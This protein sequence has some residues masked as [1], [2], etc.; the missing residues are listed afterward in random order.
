MRLLKKLQHRVGVALSPQEHY[1]RAFSQG[2][3]L[4]RDK[5]A[6]AAQLFEQ[7]ARHAGQAQDAGLQR[8]AN[9]NALLYGFLAGGSPQTLSPLLQALDGLDDIEQIGSQAEF[10]DAKALHH[11][12]AA[13]LAEATIAVLDPSA[14]LERARHHRGAARYFEAIGGQALITYAHR[15]DSLGI[16]RA[17]LRS[18]FH[19]GQARYHEALDQAHTDPEAAADAMNEALVALLQAPAKDQQQAAE[20]WLERLRTQRSCWS[21]G[22]EFLG[23]ELHYHHVPATVRGYV[24]EVLRR[25]G[26]DLASVDLSSQRVVLCATCGTMVQTIADAQAVRRVTEL[27]AEVEAQFA[28]LQHQ[29]AGLERRV[30][31]LSVR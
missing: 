15:P 10:V 30:N 19:D 12:L 2:V 20:R 9:A 22:R 14:H 13:R 26:H 31:A 23:A 8:R 29:L 7:A 25:A 3:L 21:C 27:R 6:A 16:E 4:G 28:G 18:F 24:V 1:T 11:E 17:D 5:Y